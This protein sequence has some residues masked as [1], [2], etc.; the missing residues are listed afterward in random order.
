MYICLLHIFLQLRDVMDSLTEYLLN[1]KLCASVVLP[2]LCSN[3]HLTKKLNTSLP[4]FYPGLADQK[5]DLSRVFKQS[6]IILLC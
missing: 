3:F 5:Q 1:T 4:T 6:S 2:H